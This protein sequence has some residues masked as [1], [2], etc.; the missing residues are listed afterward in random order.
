MATVLRTMALGQNFHVLPQNCVIVSPSAVQQANVGLHAAGKRPIAPAPEPRGA[1]YISGGGEL[2]MGKKRMS[3]TSHMHQPFPTT[4][5]SV[6]R[7]NARER[8]RVKQVNNGFDKLRQHI[9]QKIVEV[10]NGGRGASKKLSKVDTLRLA[11]KYIQ[12]L[13]QLLDD[14]ST[15]DGSSQG[16]GSYYVGSPVQSLQESQPPCSEASASPTPSYNSDVSVGHGYNTS[17]AP[18]QEQ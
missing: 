18:Y 12:G 3:Y 10:E 17:S 14:N 6:E 11:V 2:K 9:P 5:P 15:H 7:R 1:R 16:S 13:Q 4:P 8:N